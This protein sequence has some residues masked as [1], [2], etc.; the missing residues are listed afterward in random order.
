MKNGIQRRGSTFSYMVRIP[1][2]ATGKTKPKWV[3][4]F[5]SENEAKQARA[6]A[7]VSLHRGDYVEPSKITVGGYLTSWMEMHAETL[8]PSTRENY[9]SHLRLYLIPH[10]GNLTL[11]QLRPTHI[12]KALI[13]MRTVGGRHGKGVS[14]RT[15][16]LSA[17]ILSKALKYAVEVEGI[18]AINV[19]ERVPRPKGE[20]K[21]NE[22]WSPEQIRFFLDSVKDHELFA[23][24]RVAIYSGARL[25]EI[26][27]LNWSDL[28]LDK[29]IVTISKNRL[30]IN[31]KMVVQNS[32]KGGEGRRL[33]S[34]DSETIDIL[35]EYRLEQL[36]K[37]LVAGGEWLD[38][39]YIF[40]NAMGKPTDYGFPSHHFQKTRKK[41]HLPEQ[42]FH[43]LRHFHA[44]QLL[45]AGVPLHVVAHRLGHKDAMVTATT[46]AHVTTDQS[47]NISELFAKTINN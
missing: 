43:D 42:R 23:L 41:L 39:G 19:A 15:V 36:K 34:L 28:D 37:R 12:Q 40:V 3:G 16:H 18:L 4:G 1:D 27:A 46:Y 32:T 9:Q 24:Y 8:K 31:G 35:K 17:S 47:L 29:A 7:L 2:P 14:A 20:A 30:Q 13:A 26:L 25:G 21:R 5:R 45:R 33:V 6:K 10:L 38:S 44:T 22:P 11:S